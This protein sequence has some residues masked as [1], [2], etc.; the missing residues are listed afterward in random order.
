[1]IEDKRRNGLA[2]LFCSAAL[3]GLAGC[4]GGGGGEPTTTA[5]GV[6]TDQQAFSP[7]PGSDS[8][9]ASVSGSTTD[10]GAAS[11]T[12]AATDAGATTSAA[13]SPEGSP[14]TPISSGLVAASSTGS[15]ES[16]P[17]PAGSSPTLADCEMFPSTAIFN[18]PID[19]VSRFPAHPESGKWINMVGASVPFRTDWGVNDNPAD[20][21]S[22]WGMPINVVDG[23]PA[24]TDWPHVMFDFASSGQ[25]MEAGWPYKSDCAVADGNGFTIQRDCTAVPASTN[26]FPFPH[27]SKVLNENGMCGGPNNCGDHHVLVVETGACRLWESFYSHRLGDQWYSL[28]TAAWNLKSN[29]MRPA[30]WASADAAGLPITPLLA[31]A[32]EADS[33]EIKHALRV[34]F[35]DHNI[36]RTFDWPARHAAGGEDPGAIPFGALLRL[37]ADFVIPDDWTPQAKA[38]AKAAKRYGLYVSDNGE[39]FYVQGEPNSKWNPATFGQ[40]QNIKMSDM[41]FVDLKSIKSDPRFSNDSMAARW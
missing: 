28:V 19:D 20:F 31:K 14:A 15:P 22:Y 38:L 25:S 30:G 34:T 2:G 36:A 16:A 32:A 29:E 12:A 1:M 26:R 6:T 37:K 39:N 5:T 41:E 13:T 8:A 3:M 21:S 9:S 27:A 40:M 33:G 4:G 17:L 18:T 23:T 10:S 7:A 24:T 35:R 11:N